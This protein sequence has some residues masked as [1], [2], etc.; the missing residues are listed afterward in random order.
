LKKEN[1]DL[2]RKLEAF[3]KTTTTAEISTTT[4]T[5]T[6]TMKTPIEPS[7][8]FILVIT[9]TIHGS[10]LQSGD[11]SSQISATINAPKNNYAEDAAFA[12]VKGKLHIFGGYYGEYYKIARLDGCSLKELPARLKEERKYGHAAVSVENGR[13]AL[14][15]FGVSTRSSCETFDGSSAAPT[16]SAKWTHAYGGLGLFNNQPATVGCDDAHHQ[17]AETL[18]P[19]GWVSLPDHPLK[20]WSHSLVGLDNGA[21]LLLGG[22]DSG[23]R[24]SQ[25]G[26]WQLKEEEWSRIGELL[27]PSR[28]GS[29]IYVSRSVYYFEYANSAIYRVD[30]D[31][32]EE[33]EAV[34]EIGSQ[35]SNYY[36]PVLFQ[37]DSDYCT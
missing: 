33:I 31:D 14:V 19:T 16:F 5:T 6:T 21:M 26:I 12:L 20:I 15:C 24:S 1:E 37:T 30:L 7:D 28:S 27:K 9:K 18:S 4:K 8:V 3:E 22:W 36:W 2:K 29:A 34:E 10:F 32:N 11:G 13:K 23:S 17:K 25:T 35:P